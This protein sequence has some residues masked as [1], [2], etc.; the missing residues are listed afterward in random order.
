MWSRVVEYLRGRYRA[1]R[2][3]VFFNCKVLVPT[4]NFGANSEC[5]DPI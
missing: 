3:D 4:V 5:V 1:A 2:V